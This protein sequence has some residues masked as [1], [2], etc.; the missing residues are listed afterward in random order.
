MR[1][2]T[3]SLSRISTGMKGAPVN[4]GIFLASLPVCLGAREHHGLA[5]LCPKPDG[6][7]VRQP[8]FW[9]GM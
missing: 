4:L 3:A 7:G 8:S 5:H 1:E 9:R 2:S 6:I